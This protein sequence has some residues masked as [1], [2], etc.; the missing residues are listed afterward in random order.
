MKPRHRTLEPLV[1]GS[2]WRDSLGEG[3]VVVLM[4]S[5][6][7]LLVATLACVVVTICS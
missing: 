2:T 4:I 5:G 3:V 7:F 1:P 6:A